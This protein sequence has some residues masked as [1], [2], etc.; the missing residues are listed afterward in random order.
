MTF[1]QCQAGGPTELDRVYG[2]RAAYYKLFMQDYIRSVMRIDP[3]VI[4]ICRL[5]M[6]TLIGSRLDLSLRSKHALAAGLTE[7]K[8]QSLSSFNQ[9]PL[10]SQ[11][12][13]TCLDFAEQFVIQS[14]SIG[15]AEVAQVQ[16]VLDP[17][18]FIY[19]IK[20]LSV[21]DQFQR[22]CAAFGIEPGAEVPTH[23]RDHFQLAA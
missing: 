5:R 4:E 21:M 17:E 7:E 19:F 11:R 6:A 10:F 16:G 12:E 2:L 15:D 23:L 8:I 14:S 22:G 9:S 20:A 18:T 3:V 13:R 1:V